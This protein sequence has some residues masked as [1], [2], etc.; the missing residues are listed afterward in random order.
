MANGYW[1]QILAFLISLG[2]VVASFF[3]GWLFI[4]LSPVF[5]FLIFKF[6]GVWK[7]KERL[8]YGLTAI[9]LGIIIFFFLFSYQM[10][11]VPVQKYTY[12][13]YD[14]VIH[15]YS[16]PDPNVPA[17]VDVEY[18]SSA[19]ATLHYEIINS[20]THRLYNSGYV[21]GNVTGNVTHYSFTLTVDRGIYYLKFEINNDTTYGGE[22]IRADHGMLFNYF[23]FMSGGY[24]IVLLAVLYSLL[25]FGM[26][27]IRKAQEMTR[28]R[29]EP[30]HEG[31]DDELDDEELDDLE[32]EEYEL[33]EQEDNEEVSGAAEDEESDE[34]EKVS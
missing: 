31:E 15:N 32:D 24:V 27:S 4:I 29:Y 20:E 11:E 33:D 13:N 12:G 3:A 7:N 23:L 9:F 30:A 19:N 25:I 26:Y 17:R 10:Q 34:S 1:R 16:T 14:I 6:L 18:K 22:I 28:L 8:A 5:V 21:R 2:A